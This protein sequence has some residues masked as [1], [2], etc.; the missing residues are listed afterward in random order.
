[1]GNSVVGG[2]VDGIL[3]GAP[4]VGNALGVFVGTV[5]VGV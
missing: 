5:V 3:L 4:V 2:C 1:M